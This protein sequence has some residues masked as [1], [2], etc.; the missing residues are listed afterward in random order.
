MHPFQRAQR[1]ALSVLRTALALAI[2]LLTPAA[3]AEVRTGTLRVSFIDVGQGDAALLQ[4]DAGCN[5][6][7]DGGAPS[8]GSAVAAYLRAHGV[9]RLD[10]M[11]ATHA[12]SD[13]YGGLTAVLTATDISTTQV[14]YNGIRAISSTTWMAFEQAVVSKGL[15]LTVA[16][17]PATYQW[18]ATT[19][20]TLN[21]DPS[22]SYSDDN[23]ASVVFLV[24]HGRSR[25]LFT[26]DLPTSA[27]TAMLARADSGSWPV[28][29]LKVAH[30]GS[31][32]ATSAAFLATAMPKVA[33]ISVGPNPYGHPTVETLDR[34]STAGALVYRTD[35]SGTIV[36]SASITYS[37]TLYLPAVR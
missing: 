29:V 25:Y 21:P 31:K 33:V 16:G 13:H 11:V 14:L 28:D 23:D 9:H 7:I 30:H 20:Q 22:L 26:G 19:A 18:C 6:L 35:L 15:T 27:E 24:R 36:L 5:I 3:G 12:D 10:A 37:H 34:L 32:Y 2:L 17:Q 8:K 1:A 4:D